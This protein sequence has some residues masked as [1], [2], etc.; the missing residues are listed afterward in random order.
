MC[1]R[2]TQFTSIFLGGGRGRGINLDI[3]ECSKKQENPRKNKA[4]YKKN[5]CC[6]TLPASFLGSVSLFLLLVISN[7]CTNRHYFYFVP[8]SHQ[9][10]TELD[11]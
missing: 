11:I 3:I 10:S 4:N 9:L 8:S 5:K 7:V 2:K 1:N 6:S